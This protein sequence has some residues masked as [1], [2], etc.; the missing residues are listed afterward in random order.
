MK[1]KKLLKHIDS[2]L[3]IKLIEYTPYDDEILFTGKAK[4]VPWIYLKYELDTDSSGEAIWVDEEDKILTI[5][6]REQENV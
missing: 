3:T 1:L 4:E 5:Y 6:I 2:F